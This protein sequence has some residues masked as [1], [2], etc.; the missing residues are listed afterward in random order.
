MEVEALENRRS[1]G[2]AF[3]DGP[4]VEIKSGKRV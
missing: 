2:S 3:Q 4:E 1:K